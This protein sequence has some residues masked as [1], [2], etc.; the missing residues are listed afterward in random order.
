MLGRLQPNGCNC[1]CTA[2]AY[3]SIYSA[4]SAVSAV[5]PIP[6]SIGVPYTTCSTYRASATLLSRYVHCTR[7]MSL[8]A[9]PSAR[10]SRPPLLSVWLAAGER[11]RAPRVWPLLLCCHAMCFTPLRFVAH[12]APAAHYTDGHGCRVPRHPHGRP[13]LALAAAR[14]GRCTQQHPIQLH[15]P[16]ICGLCRSAHT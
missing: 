2:I 16:R 12:I 8:A 1:G 6:V 15:Q 7:Y 13:P 10:S 11:G 14:T 5:I 4:S 3:T 9:T